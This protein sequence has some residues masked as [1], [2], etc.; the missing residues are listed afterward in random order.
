MG[1]LASECETER[2]SLFK[3]KSICNGSRH[4]R[5]KVADAFV[6]R[7]KSRFT[8]LTYCSGAAKAMGVAPAAA[9]TLFRE[10]GVVS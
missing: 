5:R 1:E 3:Q 10:I 7:Q 6:L 9:S 2:A 8:T 4:W